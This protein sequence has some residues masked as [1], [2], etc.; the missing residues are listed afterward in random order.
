M[1][2]PHTP[3]RYDAQQR[4]TAP[5]HALR[6]ALPLLTALLMGSLTAAHA[7]EIETSLPLTSIGDKLLWSVGN[8]DFTLTVAVAGKVRLDLYSP[9]LDP[10]D[11]RSATYYGDETY[12]KGAVSTR[13][14]LVDDS[15]KTV[16]VK[17]YA[18]GPQTW[19]TFFDTTLPAGTFK[20][21]AITTGNA[22]NTFAVKLSGASASLTADHLI[23]NVHSHAFI[24]VLNVTTDGPGYELQMYDGDGPG[25]LQAQL[26]DTNGKV[27]PLP[28][29][30]QLGSVSW[31]LPDAPGHYTVELSQPQ[32]ARQYSNSVSFTM[33]HNK[34]AT[35]IAVASTDTLGLLRVEAELILPDQTL[36]TQVPVTV[37][38]LT[39]NA[40]PYEAKAPARTYPV[41][42]PP[43]AGAVVSAP[44]SVEVKKGETALVRVQVKPSAALTLVADKPEVCV[45]DVVRFTAQATTGY[46]GDLPLTLALTSDTLQL[47]GTTSQTGV[48]N[49]ATPGTVQV[50]ATATHSGDFAVVAKLG[51]WNDMKAVGVR[52]VPDVTSFQLSRSNVPSALPGAEVR[53]ALSIKNTADVAQPYHLIDTPGAG[54]EALDSPD[55]SGTLEAGETKTLS[56]RARVTGQAGA[57]S[58]LQA[59]LTGSS[60]NGVACGVPQTSQVP[61]TALTPAPVVTPEVETVPTPTPEVRTAPDIQRSSVVSLPFHVTTQAS[62]LVVAHGFPAETSYVPGSSKLDGQ[63]LPD[64]LV[65][66]SGRVYW[67]IPT[68][69][70]TKD[71]ISNEPAGKG[72]LVSGTIT[73]TL[74]HT[75]LLPAL[76]APSLLARYTRDRQDVLQGN[77]DTADFASAR[78]VGV[79]AVVAPTENAG[80]IKLP[81]AGKVF[82]ARDRI[83]VAVEGPLGT[84]LVTTVNGVTI[85]DTQIGTR[86]SD[87]NTN[88]QRLEYVGVAIRPG[89]NVIALGDQTVQVYLAGPTASVVVTP[90]SVVADGST[91]VIL[92]FKALDAAG[93]ASAEQFLTVNPSL[94]PLTPDANPSDAGY[95]IALKDGVGTLVLQPQATPTVLNVS[96][97]V[98]R[99]VQTLR[100]PVVPDSSTVG[101][102]VV[103]A[104]LGFPSGLNFSASNLTVQARAYYEGPLLGGKVYIAADKDGLPTTTNPY[105]RYPVTGDASIQTI[106]LQGIDPV[107]VNYDHPSF[108][109][110]YLQGPLPITVFSLDTNLTTLSAFSKTNPSV[111]G[112]VAFVPGDQKT[113]TLRPDGT[114]LLRLSH[115]NVSPDSES[116]Q[117]VATH[118]GLEIRRTPLTRFVDYVLDP[119]T[120]VLTLTRGLESTDADLNTLSVLVNY[121]LN[122]PLDGRTLGYGAETR[123]E[124]R[125][126]GQNFSVAAAAVSLDQKLTL[127]VRATYDSS[128]VKANVLAAYAGG[129]QASADISASLGD[130]AATLQA[131]YQDI[132][133]VGLN[134]GSTGT[135]LSA[136][137]TSRVTPAISAVLN[138]EYHDVTAADATTTNGVLDT[139][140]GSVA[141]RADVRFQPFSV[142][143]GAKYAFGDIYGIGVVGSVGYHAAPV[144]LDVVHTQPLSGNLAT[145]TD[146][147]ARVALGKVTV[148]LHDLLTWGGDDAASLTMSTVLGN[149]NV[150]V[151]YDLPTASGAGNR[152][153]F[154]VDSGLPLTD[155]LK[156]GLRGSVLRDLTVGTNSVAAGADLAYNSGDVNATLGGDVAYDGVVFKTVLR[157]GIT[158]TL[159]RTLTLT[160]D[161]TADLTPDNFGAR[162]AVGYAYRNAAWQSLGYLRY[163]DGSLS[164]GHPELSAGV[165]AEYH[166]PTLALRGGL[167]SRTLLNDE[168]S[169]TYQASVGGTY[170]FSDMLGVGAWGR[171]LVQPS[172]NTLQYG[173][174]LEGLYR[175]LPGTWLTVGYNFAG[176]EGIGSTYTRPGFYLRLDLTLDETLGQNEK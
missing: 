78:A 52:V 26:R 175:A 123:Y 154:G 110:Q 69:V 93:I 158:G 27:I 39:T 51:P 116:V 35:P 99:K 85:P 13:F 162:A 105:L 40:E 170:Y 3:S 126:G 119:T 98:G 22:K 18:P 64:P 174:G 138:G 130:T 47:E 147:S 117:L 49:A 30:A 46:A 137:V 97:L 34:A 67:V 172:S 136:N 59:S 80:N 173:Y 111:S 31:K 20:L 157:G 122:D 139:T 23:V 75:G 131:R 166:T 79:A 96:M 112:F 140:G 89:A 63:A 141:A 19:D 4:P 10:K 118:N 146:F 176:F 74:T 81:L 88:T 8:Q 148:G 29:S 132:G 1:K 167:D 100:Y 155:R 125:S 57:S 135:A 54:L 107:A 103:S 25:E 163:L 76:D 60:V 143:L 83:G 133:Y 159:S 165:S 5:R 102:G 16:F 168:P 56:Y 94:E 171:A 53:V 65:G 68:P 145:T 161:G 142:G 36:P 11:Y 121:R 72:K 129:L 104:T 50:Q 32:G 58:T 70:G 2:A 106:P 82:Y 33:T 14:E 43:V 128:V 45:G 124:V 149:T 41:T 151:G 92:K 109:A 101:V 7:Q 115:G 127:G 66:A 38:D 6:G 71:T 120:G 150:S 86:I 91:P 95:Q 42:V 48:F 108:H 37:G 160:A 144:D 169:F 113:D 156:L 21:R 114:R 90:V 15:G 152:A 9:Q 24:P 84:A 87:P 28:V 44:S 17:T 62:T 153:R 73:Y 61:F 12:D 55:F 164:A 134:A 77:F